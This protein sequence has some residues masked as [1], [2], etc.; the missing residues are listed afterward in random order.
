MQKIL[1]EAVNNYINSLDTHLR[2]C[3]VNPHTGFVSYIDIKGDFN[4]TIFIVIPKFKLDYIAELWFGDK[5]DYDIE[6][7]T[8]EIVNLIVGNAKVIAQKK[9]KFFEITTPVFMGEYKKIKYDDILKFKFKH[10]CFY[11]LF[12]EN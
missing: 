3:K 5:N 10:R 6:D 1:K 12:K 11:L 4:Y 8:K 2:E 9:G 7:L